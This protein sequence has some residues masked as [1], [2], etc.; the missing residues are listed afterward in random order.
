MVEA[1]PR[2]AAAAAGS[3][4]AGLD[5]AHI[6]TPADWASVAAGHGCMQAACRRVMGGLTV[7]RS[8]GHLA[9]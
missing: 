7:V 9:V 6:E 1:A 5:P 4:D 3:V 8:A 2:G